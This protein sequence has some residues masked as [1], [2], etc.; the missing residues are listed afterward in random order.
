MKLYSIYLLGVA[1]SLAPGLV[2]GR[3][4]ANLPHAILKGMNE[5]KKGSSLRRQ[6]KKVHTG[7][8]TPPTTSPPACESVHFILV[9][10]AKQARI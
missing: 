8:T 5:V 4:H 3:L 1:S 2:A 10:H 6:L 9:C 7:K